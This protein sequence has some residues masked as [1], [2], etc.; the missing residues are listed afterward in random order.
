MKYCLLII[1]IL[2]SSF[3]LI[4]DAEAQWTLT[5][6]FLLGPSQYSNGQFGAIHF[7]HGLL[8]AG[9]TDLWLS[10]DSGINWFQVN[11]HSGAGDE[12]T[13]ISFYNDSIGIVTRWNNGVYLT[14]DQG[15]TWKNI[16][17]V[18]D[19]VSSMFISTSK[20]IVVIQTNGYAIRSTDMG[21]TWNS[22]ATLATGSGAVHGDIGVLRCLTGSG[23]G[24]I[25][26]M[27]LSTDQGISWSQELGIIDNDSWSF[28]IDSCDKNKL[29]VM[30][31]NY[32]DPIPPSRIYSSTDGG[33]SFNI[34]FSTSHLFF[35]GSI[36]SGKNVIYCPSISNGI[37]RSTDGGL[38]WSSIGGPSNKADNNLISVIDDSI[39][40]A[41]D[42][43]GSIWR[44]TNSGGFPISY[45]PKYASLS[46]LPNSLF[47]ADTLSVCDPPLLRNL[48]ISRKEGCIMPRIT[49]Q[50]LIG[51]D[52]AYYKILRS[53]ST[54]TPLEDSITI[55]FNPNAARSF[56]ASLL[57]TFDDGSSTTIP[58][59]GFGGTLPDLWIESKSVVNDTIGATVTLPI[60]LHRNNVALTG[61][62]EFVLHYD[63]TELVYQGSYLK[64]GTAIDKLNEGWAGRSKLTIQN[65]DLPIGD[66]TIGYISFHNFSGNNPC[67]SIYF[68]SLNISI[69]GSSCLS[70][71]PFL[72]C[73]QGGCGIKEL[74]AFLRYGK[75]PNFIIYPNPAENSLT[76]QSSLNVTNAKIDIFDQLGTTLRTWPLVIFST[77]KKQAVLDVSMLASGIYFL[78]IDC[79]GFVR[80]QKVV[81]SH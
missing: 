74:S 30:S 64:K 47:S 26:I 53:A 49:K 24:S 22:G 38:N 71:N 66:D 40:V 15:A 29:V 48:V 39:I 67:T 57:L 32:Y 62:L 44:T 2:F 3:C 41:S 25:G 45:H 18:S 4:E 6:P 52:T 80:S 33:N 73:S 60:I 50:S 35:V 46:V 72:I 11:L 23:H 31:E 28:I 16:I 9:R 77:D 12:F 42:S 68:D 34:V 69:A 19:L 56:Q 76:I 78:R 10:R 27:F 63:T 37:Y 58:L 55:S 1:A 7:S 43:D 59:S 14:T 75:L 51:P 65:Q 17:N 54:G 61:P 79:G 81:V 70:Q 36:E 13:S 8:W 21:Q 20:E 5:A